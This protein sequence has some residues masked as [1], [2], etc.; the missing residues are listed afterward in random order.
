MSVASFSRRCAT[1]LCSWSRSRA[2]SLSRSACSSASLSSIFLM[3]ASMAESAAMTLTSFC[4]ESRSSR[5]A[6]RSLAAACWAVPAFS[7]AAFISS[8]PILPT[9]S[10]NSLVAAAA[11]FTFSSTTTTFSATSL[12]TVA[13]FRSA[14]PRFVSVSLL[15][16]ASSLACSSPSASEAVFTDCSD[17]RFAARR[18]IARKVFAP[19]TEVWAACTSDSRSESALLASSTGRSSDFAEGASASETFSTASSASFTR[20]VDSVTMRSTVIFSA[21]TFITAT[22]ASSFPRA[23]SSSGVSFEIASWAT[24]GERVCD[25]T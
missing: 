7:Q 22:V 9:P 23:S 19:P 4:R 16:A 17:R 1:N 25:S 3:S 5:V 15:A 14:M 20:W 18:F 24:P 13:S 11:C 8:G 21:F 2:F 6:D 10:A 12:F